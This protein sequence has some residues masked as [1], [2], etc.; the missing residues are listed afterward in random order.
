MGG[1]VFGAPITLTSSCP[2]NAVF[3]GTFQRREKFWS[4]GASLTVRKEPS[5]REVGL[6]ADGGIGEACR[7]F[8]RR[9]RLR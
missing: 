5:R 3:R 7:A 8:R 4:G 9:S 2:E 1:G 6:F